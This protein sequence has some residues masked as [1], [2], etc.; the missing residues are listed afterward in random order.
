VGEVV[1]DL[2]GFRVF[3][4]EYPLDL[5]EQRGELVAGPGLSARCLR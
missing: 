5:G 1:L 3:R 2:L 4:A